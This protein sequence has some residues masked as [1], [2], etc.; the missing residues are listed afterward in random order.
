[1]S[2]DIVGPDDCGATQST[3]VTVPSM[4]WPQLGQ[5]LAFGGRIVWH[6]GH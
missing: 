6:R 5:N 1:M 3:P 2:I 4:S